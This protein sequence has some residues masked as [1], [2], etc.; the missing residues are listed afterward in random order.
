[1]AAKFEIHAST[2]GQYRWVLVSQGRTLA[3]SEAYSRRGLADKAIVAFRMAAAAAPVVDTTVPA[4]KATTRKAARA[5]GRVVAK[6]VV[7]GGRAVE[8]AEQAAAKT[9]KRAAKTVKKAD[10]AKTT[11]KRTAPRARGRQR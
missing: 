3:T 5:V 6:A 9:A 7:K 8:T 2:T 1:M 10:T 11:T 4:P